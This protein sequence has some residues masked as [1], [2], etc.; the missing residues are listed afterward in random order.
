MTVAISTLLPEARIELPGIPEPVL[1]AALYRNIRKFFWESESWRYTSDNGLDW[2]LNQL[3][4]NLPAAGT[5]MPAK[6]VIKRVDDVKYSSTGDG[7]SYNTIL[8]FQTRDELDRY[9]AN[10]RTE[11]GSSP[12]AWSNDA[13]GYAVIT[14]QTDTTVVLAFLVRVI[15]APVFTDTADTL[16]DVLYYEN[17]EAIRAGILHEL[18]KQPGK[19]WTNAD[20][21]IFYGSM[22]ER[23]VKKARSRANA[24][25]GQPKGLMSYGG[26]GGT[27][28]AIYRDDYGQ[29]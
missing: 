1:R 22:F 12:T 19:D 11:I 14:P 7:T 24:S 20:M 29:R 10:W 3:A 23:G 17:E 16:P 27:S 13:D 25:Y 28:G 8:P 15:I 6:T 9:N 18:M 26:I 4:L 2:T 21:S 5:D